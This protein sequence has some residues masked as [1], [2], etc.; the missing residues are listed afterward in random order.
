MAEAQEDVCK[1][2]S[3][4]LVGPGQHFEKLKDNRKYNVLHIIGAHIAL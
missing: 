1:Q 2:V 3:L 4:N